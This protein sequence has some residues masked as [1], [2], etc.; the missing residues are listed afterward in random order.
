LS[1]IPRMAPLAAL[2]LALALA[3][4]AA[5]AAAPVISPAPGTQAA[6]PTTQISFLGA[7]PGS[8]SAITVVGSESGAHHGRVSAYSSQQGESFLPERPFVA[9]E[10]VTVHARWR[11]PS[12][13]ATTLAS[14]FTVARLLSL[15]QVSA[16]E[17]GGQETAPSF[18]S[19][20]GLHPPVVT[21]E[22]NLAAAASGDLFA[23]PYSPQQQSGPMIFTSSGELVWFDA[24][25][26]GQRAADFRTQVL[27]GR[28]ELT[29]W[30]GRV[31]AQGYGVGEEIVMNA[32]YRRV[33]TVRAGNGLQADEHDFV[34][35]PTGSVWLLAYSPV[36]TDL[37]VPGGPTAGIVIDNAIQ[38][39]DL[40]TGLVMWE[41]Q[42]LGHI[43]LSDS[44]SS[45]TSAEPFDYLHLDSLQLDEQG[46]L[47]VSGMNTA[48]LYCLD[49]RT[50]AILWQLGGKHSSFAL[51]AG[52]TLTAP[53]DATPLRGGDVSVLEDGSGAPGAG[54][55]A[56]AE[57]I[58][59]DHAT[60]TATLAGSLP[61]TAAPFDSTG[62]GDAQ[63]LSDGGWLVGWGELPYLSEFDAAGQLVYE[64]LLA[65]AAGSY[66]I[67]REPWIGQPARPPRISELNSDGTSTV[68]ASWNGA[69]TAT[70]WQLLT[71]ASAAHMSAVS[72][73][74]ADGFQTTIPAPGAAYYQVQALSAAGQVLASSSVVPAGQA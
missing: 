51:G 1:S 33:A 63:A 10:Q 55:P 3:F 60:A 68:Y 35:G 37:A 53:Q 21:V 62:G 22:T 25:P 28:D 72:T 67:Y 56:Q 48:A 39:I 4:A 9:G 17:A 57:V 20:P 24:L 58:K 34:L 13:A 59:L 38:E 8:L 54:E 36:A 16:A 73:T 5:A 49:A 64:A 70:S 43:P 47:L 23:T 45:P 66:R 69:T 30:Q 44:Y 52:V 7:A 2:P 41:W 50:G 61:R 26:A 46:D 74:P 6:L 18:R 71:G 11:S 14:R 15:P 31:L 12:G 19:M 27:D 29:W 42:S 65:S 40:K 32:N